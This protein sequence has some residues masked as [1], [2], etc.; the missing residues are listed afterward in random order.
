M[1]LTLRNYC[2]ICVLDAKD[3]LEK[4]GDIQTQMDDCFFVLY[5]TFDL[6]LYVETT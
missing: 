6:P 5:C 1:G 4:L 2:T 3:N